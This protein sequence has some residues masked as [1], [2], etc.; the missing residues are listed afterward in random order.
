M[1]SQALTMLCVEQFYLRVLSELYQLGGDWMA[2]MS[3]RDPE[4]V[5]AAY[6][7][8]GHHMQ[9]TMQHLI[10]AMVISDAELTDRVSRVNAAEPR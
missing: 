2:C 9:Q 3:A 1:L 4:A 5:A 10:P 8:L 6:R 7:L